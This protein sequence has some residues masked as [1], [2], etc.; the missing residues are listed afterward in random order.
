MQLK[1]L[2]G[3]V[4]TSI[5]K[6]VSKPTEEETTP[7]NILIALR[8]LAKEWVS[9]IVTNICSIIILFKEGQFILSN[10][11]NNYKK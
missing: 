4:S 5:I 11:K 8:T 10:C 9:S 1:M 3:V 2:R 7:R 6:N